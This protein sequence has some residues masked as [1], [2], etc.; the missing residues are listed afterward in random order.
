MAK[1]VE[2]KSQVTYEQSVEAFQ[3]QGYAFDHTYPKWFRKAGALFSP[4]ASVLQYST[5]CDIYVPGTDEVLRAEVGDWIARQ[6][7]K[8][9]VVKE[10]DYGKVHDQDQ[11]TGGKAEEEEEE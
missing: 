9:S 10:A 11:D 1:K 4:D 8:V 3:Y 6:G 2:Q 5:H 7:D